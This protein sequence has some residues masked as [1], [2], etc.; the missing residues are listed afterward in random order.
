MAQGVRAEGARRIPV[1]MIAASRRP[2]SGELYTGHS[3]AVVSRY[4][5]LRRMFHRLLRHDVVSPHRDLVDVGWLSEERH[6]D[7]VGV[8]SPPGL[9]SLM[10]IS[11]MKSRAASRR[12][13]VEAPVRRPNGVRPMPALRSPAKTGSSTGGPCW[14]HWGQ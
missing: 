4:T 3:Y 7:M 6:G 1:T 14:I 12:Q 8:L 5:C 9:A 2:G 13:V 10:T 11:R